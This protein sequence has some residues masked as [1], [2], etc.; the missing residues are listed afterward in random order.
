M[1]VFGEGHETVCALA[2]TFSYKLLLFNIIWQLNLCEGLEKLHIMTP[3]E[4]KL[5]S[6]S[7]VTI[8]QAG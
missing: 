7:N 6:V 2:V 8:L 1:P 3:A 4:A 5:T